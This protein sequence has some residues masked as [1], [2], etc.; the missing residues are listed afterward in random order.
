MIENNR[1][2][3]YAISVI[4]LL[5]GNVFKD[6]EVTWE[7]IVQH[8]PVLKE[9]FA[10]IG[11]ELIIHEDDGYAFLR[12]RSNDERTEQ[13]LP[14]LISKKQLSYHETL[15][16]VFLVEQL[17]EDQQETSDRSPFCTIDRKT[18]ISIMKPYMEK[19]SDGAK[20][21]KKIDILI[22]KVKKYGF[23]REL[24][25]EKDTFEIRSILFALIDNEILHVIK[26]KLLEHKNEI[27]ENDI[28]GGVND[29]T[30]SNS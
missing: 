18:I 6:D 29:A 14:S 5:K 25:T 13:A 9:Y 12:Q 4:K 2:L 23:L 11:I 28:E 21:D 7:N 30:E 26:D 3:P 24:R 1:Q 19:S 27:N 22:N 20:T 15:L 10:N 8:K 17:Y 16:C